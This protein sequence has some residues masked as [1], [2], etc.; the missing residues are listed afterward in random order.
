MGGQKN[1]IFRSPLIKMHSKDII[2][3]VKSGESSTVEFKRKGVFPEKLAKEMT[4]FANSKGGI[5]LIGVEDNGDICGVEDV[6]F[7]LDIVEKAAVFFIVPPLEIKKELIKVSIKNNNTLDIVLVEILESKIKPHRAIISKKD[8][9]GTIKSV[10]RAYIR[11]GERS[12]SATPEM[13]R[14]IRESHINNTSLNKNEIKLIEYL[15]DDNQIS[16][17]EFSNMVNISNRRALR[18]LIKLVRLEIL[19][20]HTDTHHDYYTLK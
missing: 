16:S 7:E 9:Q 5:L 19:Q 20:I 2:K 6:E 4:A 11:T 12:I 3:I 14:L 1:A 17:K 10:K 15:K 18:I 13:I 8:I